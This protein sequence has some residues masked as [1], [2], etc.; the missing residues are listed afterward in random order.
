MVAVQAGHVGTDEV[1]ISVA[2]NGPGI[3]QQN[4]ARIFGSLFSTKPNSTGM[5][6]SISLAIVRAHGGQIGY[7]PGQ[8]RG[9][10]FRFRLPVNARGAA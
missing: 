9:A 4:Q 2:D 8:P 7:E 3:A 1:E 5:G 6:L 10:C